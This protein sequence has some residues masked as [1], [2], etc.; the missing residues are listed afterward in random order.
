MNSIDR[1]A[2]QAELFIEWVERGTDT[3]GEAAR[4]ALIQLGRLYF[5]A[6][7]LPA[8]EEED[9]DDNGRE[10][11]LAHEEWKSIF[12]QVGSRLPIGYY[13]EVFNPLSVPAEEP[14]IGD[15]ADDIADVYR[16]VVE[17]LRR[18][19]EGRRARAVW[20]WTFH[21]QVHW[22]EHATGAIRALHSWLA[23]HDP[24]RLAAGS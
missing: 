11:R 2:M 20:L 9:D 12:D 17:G 24:A 4:N 21:L 1:F 6:L 22:G 8:P 16:D 14:V 7:E 3:G 10:V 5:A 18:Y 19:H 15:L 23:A 13:G